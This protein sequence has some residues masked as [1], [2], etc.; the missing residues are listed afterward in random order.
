MLHTQTDTDLSAARG[1]RA[2]ERAHLVEIDDGGD[3]LHIV[4]AG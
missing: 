3:D 2:A 1:D 4:H